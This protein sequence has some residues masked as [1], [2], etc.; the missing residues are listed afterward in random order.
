MINIQDWWKAGEI[1]LLIILKFS[2]IKILISIC[3][4]IYLGD[5]LTNFW[6][7]TLVHS[8]EILVHPKYLVHFFS[9]WT[10]GTQ[11]FVKIRTGWNLLS[12]LLLT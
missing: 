10:K 12:K 8:Q 7:K 5:Y 9:Q 6:I 3:L 1:L 11:I 4:L 2:V